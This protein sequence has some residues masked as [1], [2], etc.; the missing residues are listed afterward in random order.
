VGREADVCEVEVAD[1]IVVLREVCWIAGE[2][3][4]E[5][6][7]SYIESIIGHSADRRTSIFCFKSFSSLKF[8]IFAARRAVKSVVD[9][10]EKVVGFSLYASINF[11]ELPD[12]IA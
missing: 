7:A 9:I 1:C 6:L 3:L 5:I 8:S 2:E 12:R 4:G 11:L 10:V